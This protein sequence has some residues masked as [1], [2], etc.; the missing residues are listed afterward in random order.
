MRAARV[1]ALV[2]L[3][4][5]CGSDVITGNRPVHE[6]YDGPLYVLVTQPDH[7][8]PSVSSGAAGEALE[9]SGDLYSGSTGD[10]FGV[11]G[12]HGS[13]VDALESFVGDGAALCA[14]PGVL[15]RA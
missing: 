2:L 5:G 14:R 13:A 6:P 10:N 3:I 11:I 4:S 15:G 8:D 12:G 1:A 7:P 9:C